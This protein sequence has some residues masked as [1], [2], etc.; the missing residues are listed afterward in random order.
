MGIVL[1]MFR[2]AALTFLLAITVHISCGQSC[3]CNSGNEGKCPDGW[4]F[5]FK[6]NKCYKYITGKR[7]FPSAQSLCRRQGGDVAIAPTLGENN[8]VSFVFTNKNIWLGG[9]RRSSSSKTFDWFLN[10]KK[11]SDTTKFIPQQFLP[12]N[13][14]EPNNFNGNGEED[15]IITNWFDNGRAKWNDAIC[16][17]LAETVCERPAN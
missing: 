2:I 13:P 12:W 5:F 1:N 6:N 17:F 11:V 14:N 16:N 9:K 8:F 7:T 10:D 3:N 4:T 15:C